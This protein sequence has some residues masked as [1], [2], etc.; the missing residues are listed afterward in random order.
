MNEYSVD[1]EKELYEG[2]VESEGGEVPGAHWLE[3]DSLVVK[4]LITLGP[5]RGPE[6]AWKRA[7]LVELKQEW[8]A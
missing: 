1:D 4:G 6:N 7:E 3:A 8:R 2:L 5:A